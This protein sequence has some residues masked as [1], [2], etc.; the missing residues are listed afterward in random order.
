MSLGKLLSLSVPLLL[1]QDKIDIT[2]F[3]LA[4]NLFQGLKVAVTVS[5]WDPV[6][7]AVRQGA[8]MSMV[9]LGEG[10]TFCG[11]GCEKTFLSSEEKRI[12]KGHIQS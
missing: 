5:R 6:K 2:C 11:L 10:P 1:Q 7:S 3:I 12:F 9:V 4:T 8:V